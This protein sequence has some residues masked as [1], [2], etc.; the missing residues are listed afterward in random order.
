LDSAQEVLFRTL[1]ELQLE[2]RELR[3]ELALKQHPA[4]MVSS[5]SIEVFAAESELASTARILHMP[6]A[7][8]PNE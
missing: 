8:E 2:I 1:R 4:V 6:R 7:P 3:R 5:R